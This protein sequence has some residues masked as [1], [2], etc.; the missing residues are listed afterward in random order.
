[1]DEAEEIE[2][3]STKADVEPSPDGHPLTRRPR[4]SCSMDAPMR[5]LKPGALAQAKLH[6]YISGLV[7]SSAQDAQLRVTYHTPSPYC[8]SENPVHFAMANPSESYRP[9]KVLIVGAG[10]LHPNQHP[11]HSTP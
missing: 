3:G 8:T 2:L 6:R 5:W 4:E 9:L 11:L 1:M 7:M 10:T